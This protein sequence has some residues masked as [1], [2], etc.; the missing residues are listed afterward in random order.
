MA[1]FYETEEERL[2]RL[3][4]EAKQRAEWSKKEVV[5]A[6]KV[7]EAAEKVEKAEKELEAAERELK[8]LRDQSPIY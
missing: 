1:L 4:S 2:R 8:N 3:E 5:L 6:Q 7:A